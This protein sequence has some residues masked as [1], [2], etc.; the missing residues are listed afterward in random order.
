A[1]INETID[2]SANGGHA[3][4]TRDVAN[5]VMDLD[6][7]EQVQFRALGGA[8]KLTVNNLSATDVKQV[9]IDLAAAAGGGDGAADLV[10]VNG[11]NGNDQ[12]SVVG[13]GTGVSVTGLSA[14]VAI[15]GTE[16]G[17]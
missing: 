16:A 6:N 2:I 11:T 4:F 1:N 10:T 15:S 13:A 7:V 8:D 5:I 17:D 9:T 12:I 14:Q 3:R